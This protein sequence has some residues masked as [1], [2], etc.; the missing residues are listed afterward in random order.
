MAKELRNV[1]FSNRPF[2]VKHFQ[3]SCWINR[4][5]ENAHEQ[6]KCSWS[7]GSIRTYALNGR[8]GMRSGHSLAPAPNGSVITAMELEYRLGA[9]GA[10]RVNS[11]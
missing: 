10:G 1:C 7:I 8:Y 3:T 2:G 6:Q 11:A 4:G 5:N 9:H